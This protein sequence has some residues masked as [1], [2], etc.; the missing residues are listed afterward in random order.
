MVPMICE[1]WGSEQIITLPIEQDASKGR[2]FLCM[3]HDFCKYISNVGCSILF[4]N[5]DYSGSNRFPN[6]VMIDGIMLLHESGF[7]DA[8]IFNDSIVITIH[9]CW[10]KDGDAKVFEFQSKGQRKVPSNTHGNEF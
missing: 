7:R 10:A 6:D 2:T 8:D 3:W 9:I 1:L 4:S 5:T